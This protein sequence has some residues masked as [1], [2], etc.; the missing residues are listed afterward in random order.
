MLFLVFNLVSIYQV[1]NNFDTYSILL[2]LKA[3]KV[4]TIKKKIQID[5]TRAK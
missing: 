2:L 1:K 4:G 3:Q 5:D